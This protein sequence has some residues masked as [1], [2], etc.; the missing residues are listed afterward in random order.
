MPITDLVFLVLLLLLIIKGI[1]QGFIRSLI[2]PLALSIGTA[3]AFYYFTVTQKPVPALVIAL[4]SPF[5][6]GWIMKALLT[7]SARLNDT[8]NIPAASRFA[9]ALVEVVWGGSMFLILVALAAMLPLKPLGLGWITTDVLASTTYHTFKKPF[10]AMG[11]VS[12]ES[13]HQVLHD[14]D[15]LIEETENADPDPAQEL[16]DL[17]DDPRIKKIIADPALVEAAKNK[18][19]AALLASPAVMDLSKDPQLVAKMLRAFSNINAATDSPPSSNTPSEAS[20]QE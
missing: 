4:I 9:G 13:K 10:Q 3:A 17:A 1:Y 15:G 12:R 18:D 14:T 7:R 6:I 2:G 5:L 20:E 19:I 11:L 16:R 8:A